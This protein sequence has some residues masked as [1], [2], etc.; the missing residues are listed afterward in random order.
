MDIKSI[1]KNS[2]KKAT[3]R[4]RTKK[5]SPSVLFTRLRA[6]AQNQTI[7]WYGRWDAGTISS[8][9]LGNIS[10][11]TSASVANSSEFSALQ[12]TWT[13]VRLRCFRVTITPIQNINSL[14]QHDKLIF[15]TNMVFNQTTFTLPTGTV[16]VQNLT[17]P[18][19]CLSS[20]LDKP[21]TYVVQVPSNLGYLSIGTSASTGDS[22]SV[23]TPFAGSPGAMVIWGDRFTSSTAYFQ[24]E[25][26]AIWQLRG[27]Q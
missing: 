11:S 7:L 21:Y 9:T 25:S 23:P 13:E 20:A 16:S 10:V 17:K 14:V 27:R 12:T 1:S 3:K 6:T 5:I 22:P 24:L 4:G 8:N 26:E 2:K 18:E 19:T 15:G